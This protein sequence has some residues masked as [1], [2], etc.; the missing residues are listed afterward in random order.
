[1]KWISPENIK[2]V[3]DC[4]NEHLATLAA[5]VTE[6]FEEVYENMKAIDEKAGGFCYSPEEEMMTFPSGSEQKEV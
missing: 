3:A 6:T 4:T 5:S 1:M 2:Q